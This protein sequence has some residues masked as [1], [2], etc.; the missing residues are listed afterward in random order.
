MTKSFMCA[1]GDGCWGISSTMCDVQLV[2]KKLIDRPVAVR[3]VALAVQASS[4]WT[5][6]CRPL[7]IYCFDSA[8]PVTFLAEFVGHSVNLTYL[9][10]HLSS[11]CSIAGVLKEATAL[12]VERCRN[13]FDKMLIRL[14]TY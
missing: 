8:R 10:L 3:R 6:R 14:L 7:L 2:T 13:R 1:G 12:I 5:V 11:S 4:R 9:L